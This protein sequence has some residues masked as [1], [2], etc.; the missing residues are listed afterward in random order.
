MN[1]KENGRIN[2][3]SE[4][5]DKSVIDKRQ[6]LRIEQSLTEARKNHLIIRSH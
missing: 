1:N 3:G 5:I 6:S 4:G 2:V